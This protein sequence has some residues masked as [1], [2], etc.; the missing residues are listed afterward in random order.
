MLANALEETKAESASAIVVDPATGEILALANAP[1]FDPSTRYNSSASESFARRNRAIM[2]AY[3]PGSV[4]KVVTYSAAL[5]EGVVSPEDKI[6]CGNGQITLGSRV[7]HDSHPLGELTIREAFAKSSN[8]AAIKVSMKLGKD[9]FSEYVSRFGFGQKTNIEL[10]AETAGIVHSLKDNEKTGKPASLSRMASMAM[11]HEVGVTAIQAVSAL[12]AIAN[13]G[14]WI[15]PHLVRKIVSGDAGQRVLWESR[16]QKRTVVSPETAEKIRSMLV[17]VVE[18]GTGKRAR[19]ADYDVAGKTG[20]AQKIIGGKY[21][22][23]AYIAS[24]AGFVPASNPRY[25][26]IVVL[27]N[28]RGAHQGG[29]VAAPVF[30]EI[31]SA[32]LIDNGVL[33]DSEAYRSSLA[34]LR[35]KAQEKTQSNSVARPAA[36]PMPSPTA[37]VRRGPSLRPLRKSVEES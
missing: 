32:A 21:S 20:T 17:G 9:K 2:D 18:E 5:E 13:K 7:I 14:T 37:N 30:N 16:P 28:P 27:D 34:K 24:F 31:A 11:G 26:I 8:V 12:A 10:P 35:E 36:T 3:E 33:P 25:A 23:S 1:T 19:L 22:Q 4:F 29:Q 15:Q 6:F